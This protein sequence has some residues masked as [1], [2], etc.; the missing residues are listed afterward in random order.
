[1]DDVPAAGT[2]SGGS[3]CGKNRRIHER[4]D[5]E[6]SVG[7]SLLRHHD[8]TPPRPRSAERC[9]ILRR[10]CGHSR[11]LIPVGVRAANGSRRC[12]LRLLNFSGPPYC[13]PLTPRGLKTIV[14]DHRKPIAYM[15]A[16]VKLE[17][18]V[19]F[20][21]FA[22]FLVSFRH[23]YDHPLSAHARI[24]FECTTGCFFSSLLSWLVH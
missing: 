7:R 11:R 1:M 14:R 4:C 12:V 22:A 23:Y 16:I 21:S 2:G 3:L 13:V 9:R 5:K 24:Y 18:Q 8:T 6:H 19:H 20:L 17:A 10:R 15:L